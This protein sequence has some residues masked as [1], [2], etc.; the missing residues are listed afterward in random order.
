MSTRGIIVFKGTGK[1][2]NSQA[3]RL[4]QHCDSYPTAMLPVLRDVIRK[5]EKLAAEGTDM[6][7]SQYPVTPEMLAGLTVGEQTGIF[8]MGAR[9]EYTGTTSEPLYGNQ[10]DLEWIYVIDT[11]AKSVNVHG[12]GYSGDSAEEKVAEGLVN[13]L[14]Y[15]EKLCE[16]YQA[17]ESR[18]ITSAVRSLKRLGWPVNPSIGAKTGRRAAIAA[19]KER[20][21]RATG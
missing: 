5:A 19:Q 7:G 18:A 6:M 13:P 20:D 10:G 3:Y 2:S 15:I 9:I 14:S 11:D 4:Y 16:E 21:A 1:Y 17:K 12:G 8:G